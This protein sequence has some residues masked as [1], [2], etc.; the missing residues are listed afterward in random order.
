[1]GLAVGLYGSNPSPNSRLENPLPKD[2]FLK[3]SNLPHTP[4]KEGCLL[5]RWVPVIQN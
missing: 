5:L 1:M 3:D 4:N 2:S